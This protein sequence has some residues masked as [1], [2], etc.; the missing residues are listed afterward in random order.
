MRRI[1]LLSLIV[2]SNWVC[3]T[4]EVSTYFNIYVP[5]NNDA[6]QRNVCLV[7]TAIY[8]STYFE[9]IDDSTDGDS[10]DSYSG[11]LSAGQ[12]YILYIKDNGVNDDALYA[13]GGTLAWDGDFYEIRAS[14]LV[15]ASMATKSDWQFD[16]VPATN[17]S[18]TGQRFIVYSPGTSHSNRDLN[19]FAYEA[20]TNV[21]ISKISTSSTLHTGKST[22][23][24]NAKTVLVNRTINPG[25]D[26][27]YY[28]SDGQNIM[29]SG[30][31]YLIES[32]KDVSVQYGALFKN[33]RDGGGY[34]PSSNGSSS[35]SEF[36]FSVPYQRS[37][38]QEIRIVSWED[39]TAVYLEAYNH[40]TQIWDSLK[41]WQLSELQTADWV[42][43]NE[44]NASI[45]SVFRL[46]TE[47]NKKVSVFAANWLETGNPGTSDIATMVS[48]SNGT[49]S[50]KEFVV[51]LAPPG[52]E[53]NVVNPFTGM[54]FNGSFTHVF[55]FAKDSANISVKDVYTDGV[56]YSQ[57]FQLSKG[58]YADC[59]LSLTEWENIYNGTGSNS[60]PERPYVKIVSDAPIS[61]LNT[62]FNDNWMTYFG[63]SLSQE[64]VQTSFI[65]QEQ[66][67]AGDTLH[68]TNEV[69]IYDGTYVENPNA[70]IQI[71]S[72]ALPIE[73]NF[74]NQN[75]ST[76]LQGNVTTDSLG[77]IIVY[78][79]LP[80][81]ND[82]TQYSFNTAFILLSSEN[83]GTQI[84]SNQVVNVETIISGTVD[85]EFQQSSTSQGISNTL[86]PG[87][88][89][90]FEQKELGSA[91]ASG[92]NN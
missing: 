22:V 81:L 32:N 71:G 78:D 88:S 76:I 54:K 7:V 38:E 92:G 65:D 17:K 25:E 60:G 57:T 89:L 77:S 52:R 34:V 61:V 82:T 2:W 68:L 80:N 31:T 90:I 86:E 66:G 45:N 67:Q 53:N 28:H 73:S 42:G 12:S 85:G 51:Y 87:P 6:V 91:T 5:P 27:I 24:I 11:Y 10:D 15:Y 55:L 21:T 84:D 20:G 49:S 16:F 44:S 41:S 29:I 8:D 23:D 30:E 18:S 62:N 35:G 46:R 59:A 9:I 83:D 58:D 70:L 33:E 19:V 1:L 14:N 69:I 56:D 79:S 3:A 36:Y 39:S 40:G 75:D 72:G 50:G 74:I 37:G 43:K 26:L 63:S 64:F 47:S 48:S 4:G 13:S